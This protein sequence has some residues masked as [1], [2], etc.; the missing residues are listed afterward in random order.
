MVIPIVKYI[1]KNNDPNHINS[2]K[3]NIEYYQI[4]DLWNE[5]SNNEEFD[6]PIK[7][8]FNKIKLI[9]QLGKEIGALNIYNKRD[10]DCL[11]GL[12]YSNGKTTY[13]RLKS[14]NVKKILD[15]DPD[16]M[17]LTYIVNLRNLMQ[18]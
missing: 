13:L 8:S 6:K 14:D 18:K 17:V 12:Y 4:K 1:I 2:F 11:F 5:F 7:D 16:I 9:G 10:N 15:L 3:D